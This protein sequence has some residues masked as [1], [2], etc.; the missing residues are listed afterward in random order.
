[1]I[2][3]NDHCSKLSKCLESVEMDPTAMFL[4]KKVVTY[5]EILFIK[6][7]KCTLLS[8]LSTN[9]IMHNKLR[10]RAED[11]FVELLKF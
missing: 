2:E 4:K 3:S 6:I 8:L 9:I 7:T 11:N 1:M 10:S 5:S